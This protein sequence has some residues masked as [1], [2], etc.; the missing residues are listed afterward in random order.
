MKISPLILNFL[1]SYSLRNHKNHH[2][3]QSSLN[4]KART[5]IEINFQ[6]LSSGRFFSVPK[7]ERPAPFRKEEQKT[8][9]PVFRAHRPLCRKSRSMRSA[10]V[11]ALLSLVR[12]ES[13]I[14][15]GFFLLFNRF[16]LTLSSSWRS[17]SPKT[18]TVSLV[19]PPA[20]QRTHSSMR[21]RDLSSSAV[22]AQPR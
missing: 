13:T 6:F 22:I 11:V 9:K 12:V 3:I 16:L 5:K 17:L 15:L 1:L 8:A 19:L 21:M 7:A 10:C 4:S 18:T 20:V 2:P 14:L